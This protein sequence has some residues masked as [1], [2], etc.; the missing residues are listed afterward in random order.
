MA[1]IIE[2]KGK[3]FDPHP[4]G[5]FIAIMR[6]AYLRT[7]PNPWKGNIN[8]RGQ[9]D[10]R[11]TITDL[12]LEFLTEHLV[13]IGGKMLPGFVR[14]SATASVADNSNLRKFIKAWFPALKDEDFKRFD[15]DKLI[16][17]GAYLTVAHRTDKKG[18]VWANVVGAMQPPKGSD[19][20]TIPRDFVRHCDKPDNAVQATAPANAQGENE[21][22]GLPF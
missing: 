15:A 19:L 12:V 4:E 18:N 6:D 20:P 10:Q 3:D 7:R 2:N 14:Y 22:D 11:D 8:E 13:D 1:T 16:G 21:D 17:K 5:T 9:E